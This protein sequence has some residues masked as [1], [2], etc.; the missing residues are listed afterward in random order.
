MEYLYSFVLGRGGLKIGKIENLQKYL[1]YYSTLSTIIRYVLDG[2]KLNCL[3]VGSV[4]FWVQVGQS[5]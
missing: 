5:D 4:K 3:G 1:Q 2:H